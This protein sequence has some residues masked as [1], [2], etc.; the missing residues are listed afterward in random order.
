[1]EIILISPRD[2]TQN[3]EKIR[4]II[5]FD[6]LE[7]KMLDPKGSIWRKWDL[8]IH[9]PASYEWKGEKFRNINEDNQNL[10][11][12]KIVSKMETSDISVF[13]IMDYWTFD[14]YWKI[15]DYIETEG[16]QFTKTV[17]PGMEIRVTSP[18]SYRLNFHLIL[19][20][21]LSRQKLV[22]FKNTLEIRIGTQTRSL[23]DEALI[24]LGKSFGNDKAKAQGFQKPVSEMNIDEL[25]VFGCKTA[26]ITIESVEKA[27]KKLP[28]R[29]VLVILP[30]DTNDGVEKLEWE[31]FPQTDNHLLQLADIFESRSHKV[32]DLIQGIRTP[33][34]DHIFNDFQKSIG[35]PKPVIAGSDAHKI[36]DYGN[37]PS[38]KATWIKADA[39]WLGLCI[40]TREPSERC[41]IGKEPLQ[42]SRINENSTKIIN[43]LIVKKEESS[44]LKEIWFNNNIQFNP[45][46]ITIIG[47]KGSGKSALADILG[48]LT[49][50][51]RIDHFPFLRNTQFKEPKENKAGEFVGKLIWESGQDLERKLDENYKGTDRQ[52]SNYL[53]QD[54]FEI[55]CNELAS[56]QGSSFDKELKAV[57]FSHVQISDRLGQNSLDELVDYKTTV[58]EKKLSDL[59]RKL[60]KFNLKIIE[61]D[62]MTTSTHRDKIKNL[63]DGKNCELKSFESSKPKKVQKPEENNVD[64]ELNSKIQELE[65]NLATF[66][67]EIGKLEQDKQEIT[68]Q[69]ADLIK[70]E[71]E[72]DNVMN[73]FDEMKE[74]VIKTLSDVGLIFDEIMSINFNKTSLSEKIGE[75][76]RKK[77][78]ID[79]NL[80]PSNNTSLISRR[81]EIRN[82]VDEKN[83]ELD[84]PNKLYQKY[85]EDLS[86]WNDKRTKIIG[87][88]NEPDTQKYYE[89]LLHELDD[90]PKQL[91]DKIEERKNLV[92]DIHGVIKQI[93][94]IYSELYNPV[95][96]FISTHPLA[97][98]KINLLFDVSITNSGFQD[99]FFDQI[100]QG[101]SGS[102]YGKDEGV[103]R[104]NSIIEKHDYSKESEVLLFLDEL[105]TLLEFDASTGNK[106]LVKNQLKKNRELIDLYDF[107]YSLDYLSPRYILKMGEKE[108]HELSP[109]EKGALLLVFYLLIDKSDLPLILDQP[110]HNLDNETIYKLLVPAIKEAKQRRQLIVVTHNPNIAVVCDA[111][112]V[113]CANI[114]KTNG[115]K[116]EYITGG[117]ENPIINNRIIQVLEGTRPAFQN[118]DEKYTLSWIDEYV[119]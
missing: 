45:G 72:F 106:M 114:D 79:E 52:T 44:K 70:V 96:K 95:Q 1:M 101:V 60:H 6:S 119:Y 71:G 58:I 30:Y 67:D 85:L 99:K 110:E 32:S 87:K 68:K 73:S 54:Y 25:W 109:G 46:L 42:I 43:G 108:L 39:T 14:G 78:E 64:Q 8:H 83:K 66:N 80:N 82:S 31:S 19:S 13:G 37:F 21:K 92:K 116:V 28:E 40:A 63:L 93:T 74:N 98:G 23:S 11:V 56:S 65:L 5:K 112:Q 100:H 118:R 20:N 15:L 27:I 90:I 113:I 105:Q 35:R 38:S 111:D 48:L 76:K 97:E 55:I 17:F 59:R 77:I 103:Q 91:S 33:S 34:N 81:K 7:V 24:D 9:T 22:E 4:K 53:P 2:E 104:I 115:N 61:L 51:S 107:I 62:D 50:S 49:N 12:Q 3:I 86:E 117:I 18:T 16:S 84:E 29:S 10:L 26:E 41:F 47:N 69:I 102:F 88:K 57:V 89:A 94:E 36:S 75:L